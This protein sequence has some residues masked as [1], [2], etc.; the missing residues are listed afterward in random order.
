MVTDAALYPSV[1]SE[2]SAAA[3]TQPTCVQSK[4]TLV[5]AFL[6]SFLFF[7]LVNVAPTFFFFREQLGPQCHFIGAALSGHVCYSADTLRP[8]PAVA[9][10]SRSD[11][12]AAA[13]TQPVST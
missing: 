13:N 1:S 3:L 8:G 11:R 12:P 6:C 9:R 10:F 4:F 2:R 7:S 5:T